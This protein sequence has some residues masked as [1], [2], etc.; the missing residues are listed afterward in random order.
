LKKK[1]GTSGF[2][3]LVSNFNRALG[4]KQKLFIT[5]T[6]NKIAADYYYGSGISENTSLVLFDNNDQIVDVVGYGEATLY[7]TRKLENPKLGEVWARKNMIDTDDN[8]ADFS[9]MANQENTD[10]NQRNLII[11][12]LL[13]NPEEGDEWFELFNPTN[14]LVSLAGLKVCDNSGSIHCYF[15]YKTD[16]IGSLAYKSYSQKTT[17]I[18]L[19]DSG[20][21]LE[22][23]DLA[24]NLIFATDNFEGADDGISL[25]LF[26]SEWRWTGK[27]TPS[28]QNVFV[29]ILEVEAPAKAKSSKKT[30]ATK[31]SGE[32]GG[33]EEIKSNNAKEVK[34]AEAETQIA[35]GDM[36]NKVIG[37]RTVGWAL[38]ALAIFGL[39]SYT[40]LESK[41][42]IYDLYN[43]F[44]SRNG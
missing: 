12:E 28:L 22:L 10:P 43:R 26:G 29:D 13:P 1:P 36:G 3:T 31:K 44:R 2:T 17:K 32:N 23:L 4:P 39:V 8:L 5:Y 16:S 42:K 41:D 38:V 18:T 33:P 19:N 25:S 21:G 35:Q 6:G 15:F 11:S 27:Q 37:K 9:I 30:A 14:H 7:E 24:D 20:D 40:I 34:A